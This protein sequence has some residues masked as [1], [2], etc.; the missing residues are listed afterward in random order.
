MVTPVI[1]AS[2]IQKGADRIAELQIVA[3]AS[4]A[5]SAKVTRPGPETASTL[6]CGAADLTHQQYGRTRMGKLERIWWQ[7]LQNAKQ[8]V[9]LWQLHSGGWQ[10]T[11][12]VVELE[13]E[14]SLSDLAD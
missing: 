8:N 3:Q 11:G 13:R 4:K 12:K 6:V 14:I 1:I 5:A 10:K 7:H 2:Q 9:Q